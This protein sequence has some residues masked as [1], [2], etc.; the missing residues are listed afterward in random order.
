MTHP[1][2]RRACLCRHGTPPSSD[3]WPPQSCAKLPMWLYSW[4]QTRRTATH[5]AVRLAR[6]AGVVPCRV[7]ESGTTL[8][9][10]RLRNL[11]VGQGVIETF[12][13]ALDEYEHQ[14]LCKSAKVVRDAIESLEHEGLN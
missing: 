2:E 1:S 6:T 5:L 11:L 8:D 13:P 4:R 9:T 10:A 12:P 7:I 3:P 14:A